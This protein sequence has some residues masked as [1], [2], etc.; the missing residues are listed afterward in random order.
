MFKNNKNITITVIVIG[1]IQGILYH[2]GVSRIPNYIIGWIIWFILI[3]GDN[4]YTYTEDFLNGLFVAFLMAS[5]S[6]L[7]GFCTADFL[8]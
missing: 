7:I 6:S 3:K 8:K 2:F 4:K 1:L 5:V